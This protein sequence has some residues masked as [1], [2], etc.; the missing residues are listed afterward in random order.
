MSLRLAIAG[1]L[2]L[3][4]RACGQGLSPEQAVARMKPVDGFQ[5]TLAA[6]EPQIRQPVA[7]DFDERGRLWV[8]Q[9]LQYPNPAGLKRMKVDRYSRTRYDRVPEPPPKGPQGADRLTILEP[10]P[11]HPG[12]LLAKDFVSGLNLASG[13]AF[14]HGGVF[15]LQV[16]YLLFYP[17]RNR[18]D[19]PDADPEVLLEGFGMEDA[20]SVANSLTWGPDGWLYGCQG[21]TVT[22]LIRGIEFQQGVWRYHPITRKFELFCEGGGNSWGLDF[23]RHGHLLYSTNF[24]PHILLH[25]AQG[26]Y[27]WKQFGKHGE[28]HNRF[29]YDH[30]DH[31]PHANPRGGHVTTGGILY[32]GGQFPPEFEGT[33]LGGD[34]LGHELLWHQV[35]PNGSSFQTRLG[36]VL[37]SGNDPWFA[38][39]DVCLGPDGCVYVADWHDQRTAHPDPD[40]EWDRS[41]GRVF[42]ISHGKPPA[43]PPFDMGTLSREQLLEE[44]AAKNHWRARTARRIIAH[45]RDPEMIL[46]L[47]AKM[48]EAPGKDSSLEFLWAL[49]ACG[50][51]TEEHA[52]TLLKDAFP[53]V[54]MWTAQLLGDRDRL[55]SETKS[56]LAE[57]ARTETNTHVI[58]QLA[59]TAQRV[60]ADTGLAIVEG[61]LKNETDAQD[62][63]IPKLLWWALERHCLAQPARAVALVKN[64]KGAVA[65]YL[66]TRL[67]RRLTAAGREDCDVASLGLGTTEKILDAMEKGVQERPSP[68]EKPPSDPLITAWRRAAV[69]HASATRLLARIGDEGAIKNWM[70]WVEDAD[71]TAT[72]RARAL[73]ALAGVA[74]AAA[75]RGLL[76]RMKTSDPTLQ[77]AF[78]AAWQR[79]GESGDVHR[80]VAAY[81]SSPKA[82]QAKIRAV[83]LG[84]KDWVMASLEAIRL[85]MLPAGD[86]TTDE[87][88]LLAGFHD[89]P[90]D[91]AVVAI[92]GKVQQPTS[93]ERLAEIRRLNNDLRAGKGEPARGKLLFANK[94]G[95]CHKFQ[96]E[97]A[98]IGPDLTQ[99]NRSDSQFLL[100][101]LVDPSNVIR[102]EYLTHAVETKN[103][104]IHSGIITS[105]GGDSFTLVNAKN[106]KT[107]IPR[108]EIETVSESSVSLMPENLLKEITPQQ[109]R[110]LFAYIQQNPDSGKK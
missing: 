34:L 79:V 73:E 37:L 99:A 24:G 83:L 9:Y 64:L 2:L 110:D 45:R 57:M 6:S 36:G 109:L 19:R 15:V 71:R 87:V 77:L 68:M 86:F 50:G 63:Q 46:P 97:G 65:D 39:C 74:P 58:R 27:F 43:Q 72:E 18:D 80:L 32:R 75:L 7:I 91:R 49:H 69:D 35:L 70:G 103:G 25:G 13:F 5:V 56:L 38:P 12:K 98:S 61:L 33:Y 26:G 42:R 16:P 22:A 85:K 76:E 20:H 95:T 48:A 30:I 96:G 62:P 88:R 44:L 40:A 51:L 54:R 100:A 3:A 101:S 41:N 59:C 28:L 89:E 106:E 11:A 67:A 102:K 82:I 17:D 55:S 94:C 107:T 21:S 47:Q 1:I 52:H 66:Q 105:Q 104:V 4:C 108:G 8:M 81:P 92:W 14:G 23:D 29:A 93:E 53:P 84:R 10:D 78:L 60:P 31:A 90:I